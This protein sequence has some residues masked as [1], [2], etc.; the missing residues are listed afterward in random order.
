[1]AGG[2][3]G[4]GLLRLPG[5]RQRAEPRGS[6]SPGLRPGRRSGVTI[7]SALAPSPSFFPPL[8]KSKPA[9]L[10][11]PRWTSDPSSA[12]APLTSPSRSPLGRWRGS[13]GPSEPMPAARLHRPG[14]PRSA[15][16]PGFGLS[17]S[18][19]LYTAAPPRRRGSW[20]G[21]APSCSPGCRRPA[22]SSTFS[23][24]VPLSL[25]PGDPAP[26]RPRR[27]DHPNSPRSRDAAGL[28]APRRSQDALPR[29]GSLSAACPRPPPR[30]RRPLCC[31]LCRGGRYSPPGQGD[32]LVR[33]VAARAS[34]EAASARG[35][36]RGVC[37]ARLFS[38]L[39]PTPPGFFPSVHSLPLGPAL[40][41]RAPGCPARTGAPGAGQR[42]R[43][44]LLERASGGGG[45][46]PGPPATGRGG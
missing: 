13:P 11:C 16:L 40:A 10:A 8:G 9:S 45:A 38:R 14:Q 39:S 32:P 34:P 7:P 15:A 30:S 2:S 29:G 20:G 4:S 24:S 36:G 41:A 17:S 12:A 21:E 23:S 37:G 1:M 44:G 5:I 19:R 25:A 35:A 31:P 42:R 18:L 3:Q 26:P 33:P 27:P 6:Q 28:R 43:P 22:P 46:E